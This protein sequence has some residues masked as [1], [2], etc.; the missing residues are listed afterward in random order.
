[1]IQRESFEAVD[2]ILRGISDKNV[3]LGGI[4]T[5]CCEDFRHLLPVV[6]R[7]NDADV[8]NACIAKSYLWQSFKTF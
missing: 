7:G 6:K 3:T 2:L 4:L 5:I 8:T 1:M